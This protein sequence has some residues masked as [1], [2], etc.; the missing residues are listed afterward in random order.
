[1]T[2][3]APEV[4]VS[5]LEAIG[6]EAI[7]PQTIDTDTQ[8][9]A[10]LD[11][12]RCQHRYKNGKRCRL[13]GSEPQFGLCPLHFRQRIAAGLPPT[14]DSSDLSTDLLR[15]I[16]FSSAEDLRE[17]LT[18]LLIQ[19]AKGRVSPRRASV[20]AYITTQLLHTHV[21]AEKESS[22][23]EPQIIFD[24]PSPK[25]DDFISPER[26]SV[27]RMAELSTRAATPVA[28]DGYDGY[29]SSPCAPD[30]PPVSTPE[31]LK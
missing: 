16:K 15:G 8:S 14:D 28:P 10:L 19:M 24:L 4:E 6:S 7:G 5:A 13:P 3:H 1:M 23:E 9:V 31:R 29:T 30:A 12:P 20:L 17:F 21:A 22:D 18:R 11:G 27:S 2:T 26:D 25:R